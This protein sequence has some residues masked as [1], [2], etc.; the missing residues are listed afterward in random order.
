[1]DATKIEV[2][3]WHRHKRDPEAWLAKAESRGGGA[4]SVVGIDGRRWMEWESVFLDA[5]EPWV[6][7][8][9]EWVRAVFA[10]GTRGEPQT[11]FSVKDGHVLA[12]R[13]TGP[14]SAFEPCLPPAEVVPQ[15]TAPKYTFKKKLA[16]WEDRAFGTEFSARAASDRRPR[17]P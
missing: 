5:Y 14:V 2:G 4:L 10:H 6:P 3:K 8:V 17:P 9:G 16:P 7:R 15:P 1:M 13:G 11:V 12:K